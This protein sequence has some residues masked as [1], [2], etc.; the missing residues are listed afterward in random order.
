MHIWNKT[1][2]VQHEARCC[3]KMQHN[4]GTRELKDCTV[5]G[6]RLDWM[7]WMHDVCQANK[8]AASYWTVLHFCSRCFFTNSRNDRQDNHVK[9]MQGSLTL[10]PLLGGSSRPDLV[11]CSFDTWFSPW[12]RARAAAPPS[13]YSS[14]SLPELSLLCLSCQWACKW[15]AWTPHAVQAHKRCLWSHGHPSDCGP[16]HSRGRVLFSSHL[17]QNH[18]TEPRGSCLSVLNLETNYKR[19][20]TNVFKTQ[21]RME[22]FL[23]E[24]EWASASFYKLCVF[25]SFETVAKR[26]HVG[27]IV[28]FH[29]V[30]LWNWYGRWIGSGSSVQSFFQGDHY[31][32]Q[33]VFNPF[34]SCAFTL[35][36]LFTS[37]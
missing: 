22:R 37:Y 32:F 29:C 36:S 1:K 33:S 26:R 10:Q 16:L 6:Q 24:S 35:P 34:Q 15:S 23:S 17:V 30:S 7:T 21:N 14:H 13:Y 4:W 25:V 11:V 18:Y 28:S 8:T 12:K 20:K 19:G 9:E 3:G 5:A 27:D 31:P 2:I